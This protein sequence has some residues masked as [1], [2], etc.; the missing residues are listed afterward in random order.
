MINS[1]DE[2]E[3]VTQINGETCHVH[4]YKE[5]ILLRYQFSPVWPIDSTKYQSIS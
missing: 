1:I 5:S 2:E 3:H 4:G